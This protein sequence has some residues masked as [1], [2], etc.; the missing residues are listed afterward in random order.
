MSFHLQQDSLLNPCPIYHILNEALSTSSSEGPFL[1]KLHKAKTEGYFKRSILHTRRAILPKIPN[2]DFEPNF[3]PKCTGFTGDQK[4]FL[5][6]TVLGFSFNAG[7]TLVC[8][9]RIKNIFPTTV[10]SAK[11]SVILQRPILFS[12]SIICSLG[13]GPWIYKHVWLFKNLQNYRVYKIY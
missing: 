8:S 1:P 5:F 13:R 9:I 3:R 6:W 2:K 10:A 12:C 7:R 11:G 4:T